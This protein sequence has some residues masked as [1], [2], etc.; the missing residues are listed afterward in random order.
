MPIGLVFFETLNILVMALL[1]IS[2]GTD[3]LSFTYS[4][5]DKAAGTK[6]HLAY[7]LLFCEKDI[8][9]IAFIFNA[10]HF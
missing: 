4:Q 8:D 2:K 7:E 1:F 6:K 5:L 3:N 10:S 9:D